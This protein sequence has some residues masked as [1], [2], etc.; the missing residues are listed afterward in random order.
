MTIPA[1]SLW[2]PYASLIAVCAKRFETR[3]WPAPLYTIGK[4]IAIHA[5]KRKPTRFEIDSMFDNVADALGFCHW[6]SRIPYGAVICTAVLG[7]CNQ[8]AHYDGNKVTFV[9]GRQIDDD[10]FGDY[11]K[12]RYCWEFYDVET[13]DPVPTIG[14]QGFFGWDPP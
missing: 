4:R 9:D 14:R 6:P 5:A 1:I 7:N 2:Q 10:G 11:S 13:F 12:G 8:V 3:H